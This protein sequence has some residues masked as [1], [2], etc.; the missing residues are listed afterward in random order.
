MGKRKNPPPKNIEV[1]LSSSDDENENKKLVK[2][3]SHLH[4]KRRK[5]DKK[6]DDNLESDEEYTPLSENDEDGEDVD[7][8]G[9]IKDLISYEEDEEE[10]DGEEI[11]I[12]GDIQNIF[13]GLFESMINEGKKSSKISKLKTRIEESLMSKE[14]K[15]NLIKK[16]E[17]IS[18]LE[19]KME[20]WFEELLSIPFGKYSPLPIDINKDDVPLYFNNLLKTL[21]SVVYGLKNVKE[22]II[23]YVAQCLSSKIPSPRILALQG[24]AGTGKT[25]IIR[26]GI[27]KV[28]NTPMKSF[29]MGG[30]KDSSHFVGFDYTY[31]NSK[32][33]AISQALID[34]KVMNPVIFLDELDKI[35][36]KHDGDEVENLLI[37]LTDPIQNHQFKDKYFDGVDIDLSKVIFIFAFNNIEKINPIL[38]DRIHVIK[39]KNPSDNDK[40]IIANNYLI[41]EVLS[42]FS[43]SEEG[44]KKCLLK[45]DVKLT[46]SA[47][48]SI[49]K[50]YSNGGD[51]MR[52]IKDCI[53]T[54]LLK[55]NTLKLLG[56]ELSKHMNLSFCVEKI[57]FPFVV[58]E[59][60]INLFLEDKCERCD[61]KY[62]SMYM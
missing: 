35:S 47:V 50:K 7:D 46:D 22:E 34:S 45:S 51:G 28:L 8:H 10:M 40:L 18:Q 17:K 55:I 59:K 52:S 16:L 58:D 9:N 38:L 27:A 56:G 44:V 4:T 19:P 11:I 61:E 30:I 3:K 20:E 48:M 43:S 12:E 62:M 37:H 31:Q 41:D 1:D 25:R 53:R 36:G 39:I 13:G 57:S 29:S 5:K 21:D 49:I 2:N 24:S 42:G 6:K 33:G 26:D 54:I 14:L 60:N 23:T 15:D 32:F